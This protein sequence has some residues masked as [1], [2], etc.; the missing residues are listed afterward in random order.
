M[1]IGCIVDACLSCEAC[2]ESDENYCEKGFTMTYNSKIT[3]GNLKTNAEYTFGGYSNKM[4][5]REDFIMKVMQKDFICAARMV[6]IVLSLYCQTD[7]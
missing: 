7:S 3:H 5:A 4:T 6:I 1:G 2:Q